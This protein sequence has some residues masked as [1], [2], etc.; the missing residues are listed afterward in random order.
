MATAS[1]VEKINTA[2]ITADPVV[3]G[4]LSG[5]AGSHLSFG[6]FTA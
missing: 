2:M 1:D 3:L 4:L 6:K 5:G